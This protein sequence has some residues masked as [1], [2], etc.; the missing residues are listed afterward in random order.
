MNTPRLIL[1]VFGLFLTACSTMPVDVDYDPGIQFQRLKHY[2]WLTEKAP[3][4]GNPIIDSDSL[5]HDRLHQE[6]DAWLAAHGYRKTT[7][8]QA[9]FLLTYRLI[10]ED[11]TRV[12]VLNNYYAYPTFW[13]YGYY[14][15]PFAY[16]YWQYYPEI[17][18]YEYQRGTFILDIIN[19]KTQ[20]LMWRG[21]AYQNLSR[22]VS[23]QEL[24]NTAS[25]AILKL[26]GQFAETTQ[27][28]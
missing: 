16:S 15:Y 3:K 17:Q 24:K 4:S 18:T 13:S 2:A 22:N 10:M 21:M 19:P 25:K 9:D 23:Q 11:K 7:R 5:L 8:K 26:L 27:S 12:S 1:I 14:G 28:D 6:A 20:K